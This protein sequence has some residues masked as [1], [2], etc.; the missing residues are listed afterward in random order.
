MQIA[1]MTGIPSRRGLILPSTRRH[2]GKA[3]YIETSSAAATGS[4]SNSRLYT[5]K[6]KF[7]QDLCD[8]V[9]GANSTPHSSARAFQ[10]LKFLPGYLNDAR[11]IP[12]HS[13]ST[14]E[15]ALQLGVAETK[16]LEDLLMPVMNLPLDLPSEAIYYQPTPGR[17]DLKGAMIE[18]ILDLVGHSLDLKPENLVIGAGCNAVLENLCFC[19]TDPGDTVLIPTPYYAAFEFDLGSRAGLRVQGFDSAQFHPETDSGSV[20]TYYPS[21]ASLDAAYD[22][23]VEETNKPPR[24]LLISHPM[25]PL[26]ICYPAEVIE[27]CI[28]WCRERQ[29]HLISDE[30]YA[31]SV[32]GTEFTSALKSAGPTLGPFVHWVYALSKDFGLSGMRVG[33]A[34]TENEEVLMALQKLNDLCQVSSQTQLWTQQMLQRTTAEGETWTKAFR[35]ENHKRLRERSSQITT[36]LDKYGIP[37]L[38]PT[39]GL[40]VW[41][42]LSKFLPNQADVNDVERTLYLKLIVQYGLLF[43]PGNSMRHNAPGFFR[44]VFTAAT[45]DEFQLAKERLEK[46]LRIETTALTERTKK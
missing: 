32:Y 39:A 37:H 22:R 18:Y 29:V 30:I 1:K 31:G 40:F 4:K 16:M 24:V 23:C 45:E 46:L 28:D 17:V 36:I 41:I 21:L 27:E 34:Y 9:F 13:E 14:P 2:I 15:G 33:A 8:P 12:T 7:P 11:A 38:K 10:A 43:T 35:K 42:D 25:N 44:C 19:I 5:N 6:P 3:S 26:G 20:E